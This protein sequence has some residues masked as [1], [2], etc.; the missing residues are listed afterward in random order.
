MIRVTEINDDD[1]MR[2]YLDGELGQSER[3][4]FMEN[5]SPVQMRELLA[6]ENALQ[7]LGNLPSLSVPP[8]MASNVMAAIMP[9]KLLLST[10]I[11]NWLLRHSA[12]LG[13]EIG[14]MAVAA[15]ALFLM[16]SPDKFLHSQAASPH[17][18]VQA[19]ATIPTGSAPT[20]FSLY[21]PGARSVSLISDFNG[22]SSE[23]SVQLHPLGHDEWGVAVKLPPGS[24]Q[25]AF[26]INGRKVVTDPAARQVNDD[27]G[28]KNAIVTVI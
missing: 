9:D 12:L 3:A 5:L 13:L 27:F 14:S 16:L 22:W 7:A 17:A 10:R 8:D 25:Y 15:I 20:G 24:Y 11:K 28:H 18:Y 26:L 1:M 6:M 21:A 4:R 2:R 19:M 23:H